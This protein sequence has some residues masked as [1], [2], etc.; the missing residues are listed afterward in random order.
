MKNYH[1]SGSHVIYSIK[2]HIIFVT[3]Y[4]RKVLN[5]EMLNSLELYISNILGSYN[6]SLVEF[7][8]ESDHIHFIADINPN[9]NISVLVNNLKTATSRR[10]NARFEEHLS[11]FY[12]KKILWHRSY[13]VASVGGVTLETLKKYVENQGT[14]STSLDPTT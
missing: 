10:I 5:K 12:R 14:N 3:K 11:K 2:L 8:G 4:R 7:G 6:S 9:V 13:F 1:K